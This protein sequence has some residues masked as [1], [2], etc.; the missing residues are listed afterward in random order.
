[1][2]DC[3]LPPRHPNPGKLP[4]NRT[5][6]ALAV[7]EQTAGTDPGEIARSGGR[8]T[9]DRFM[10]LALYAPGLGYYVAG[11]RKFGEAG[12]FVTAPEISPL[13][14]QCLARQ[15]RQVLG[16][17]GDGDILEFGAGSGVLAADMLDGTAGLTALPGA[18]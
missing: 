15:T 1:M 10:E 3:L 7:S 9:F 14:A 2:P 13:F 4:L 6:A 16:S 11:S 17:S 18:T 12:D 5:A 8:I